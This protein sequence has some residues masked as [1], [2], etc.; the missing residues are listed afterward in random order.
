MAEHWYLAIDLKSFYASVECRERGLDPLATNLVVADRSRTDKT[1]CL[2]VS[3]SLKAYGIP[4]RPRLFEVERKV[5]EINAERQRKAPG[6]VLTGKSWKDPEVRANPSLALDYLAA[7]PRMAL[8]MEYSAR[9]YQ[10]YLQF[11][12]PEDIHVYSIDEVFLDVT[13][14]LCTYGLTARQLAG[15]LIR[16]VQEQVGIAAAG[17]VGTNLYLAKVAMDIGAKHVQP[18]ADGVRI[19]ELDEAG[20][21]RFLWAH[22]PLTD[23]WRVGPGYARKLEAQGL[24]TMGDIARCSVGKETDY[25][26]EELLYRMFG[27]NA[28]LLI[29]HAWGWEPCTIAD[30]KAYRPA[31]RSVGAG[32]VLPR[33]YP[34]EKARLVVREMAD[35]LSL[36]LAEHRLVTDQLVLTVGYD[37]ENLRRGREGQYQG[38]T[39]LDREG[40]YQGETALDRY[41]RPVPRHAH[42]TENLKTF[43]ASSRRLMEAASALFDRVVDPGLWIRR[44]TLSASHAQPEEK[45][46]EAGGYEQLELFPQETD[47]PASGAKEGALGTEAA[48]QEREE[49]WQKALLGIQKRFGKNAVLRGMS[50]EEGATARERNGQIGGHKA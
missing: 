14:Y 48:W 43:T 37:R 9:V 39:A 42:G 3:P 2:A 22:R 26:N 12:A 19:A 28:E 29:D 25:Y 15:R 40:Q 32:Q 5:R 33:P 41:G 36:D 23:F 1:I 47:G 20:Y 27:V 34:F 46:R 45:A 18:D 38:E 35:R 6:R 16:A 8:Y 50:L 30:I 21:R 44:L 17:G 7:V 10:V 24:Y 13:S 4:G 49:K 31:S 11:I